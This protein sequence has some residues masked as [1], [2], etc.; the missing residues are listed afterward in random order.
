MENSNRAQTTQSYP[1]RIWQRAISAFSCFAILLSTCGMIL[2]ARAEEQT[3]HCGLEEHQ[4]TE[5]CY[6]RRLVCDHK[7]EEPHVHTEACYQQERV[8]TCGLE[9][10]PGHVHDESCIGEVR[11]LICEDTSE[12]H[13]HDDSCYRVEKGYVC[14]KEAGEG[15]HTHGD[16][17]YEM[18]DV[19]VCKLH[20]HTEECQEDVLICG[21]EAHTHSLSCYSDPEA[22]VESEADWEKSVSKVTLTGVWAED[23][24]AIAKSQLGYEESKRNYA[25]AQDGTV[26]GYTRYGEWYGDPYGSWGAMFVSFCL[27]YAGISRDSVPYE[28]NLGDWIEALSGETWGLYRGMEDGTPRKGDIVF[29]DTNED[30]SA[31]QVGLVS[32]ASVDSLKLIVGD[33]E[34]S[35][36][37]VTLELDSGKLF[38]FVVLPENPERRAARAKAAAAANEAEGEELS[39]TLGETLNVD[40]AAGETVKIP[41][42]PEYTHEYIFQSTGSGDPHGYIYNTEGNQL[43]YNDDSGGNRQFQIAYTLAAGQTYYLW[44]KWRGSNISG[45]IPV[46]LTLGGHDFIQNESG[47]YECGC[48]E[49]ATASEGDLAITLDQSLLVDVMAEETVRIPFVPEITHEYIFQSVGTGNPYGYIYGADG[50]QLASDDNSGGNGQ[51]KMAYTM[52]AGRTYYLGVRW[53]NSTDSGTIP[54]L[55]TLSDNHY[56]IRNESGQWECSCSETVAGDQEFI[57]LGQTLNVYATGGIRKIPFVPKVTHEYVFQFKAPN[58]TYGYIYDADGKMLKSGYSGNGNITY[59]LTAGGI[60]YLGVMWYSSNQ[61]GTIPLL[62]TLGNHSYTKDE[63]GKYKCACGET[64]EAEA[65]AITLDT[66]LDVSVEAGETVAIPFV[67]TITH[68]YV[69]Q[70][71]G[72]GNPY[73]YIYDADGKLLQSN[74]N[75]G[76]N[77]QFKITRT[78][79]AGETYCLGVKWNSSTGSGTIPLLLTLGSHSYAKDEDGQF[80]CTCGKT[81]DG[82]TLDVPL[83]VDVAKGEI[84]KIPF[85]PMITHGYSF[86]ATST[87]HPTDG[88]IYDAD[89]KQLA[90]GHGSAGMFQADYTLTAGQTYYLG[91]KWANFTDSG[92]IPVLLTYGTH[93]YAKNEVGILEC[94]CGQTSIVLG[95]TADIPVEYGQTERLPFVPEFTHE[96]VFSNASYR[97]SYVYLYDANGKILARSNYGSNSQITHTMAAGKTYYLGVGWNGGYSGARSVLLT[98]GSHSYAEDENGEYMCTCGAT[99]VPEGQCGGSVYWRYENGTLRIFGSGKMYDY[100]TGSAP[101]QKLAGDIKRVVVEDGVT[102]IG[103]SAF[104]NCKSLTSVSI[105]GSV[106]NIGNYTFQRCGALTSVVI[107]AGVTSIGSFAFSDCGSLRTAII[108]EGV[109]SIGSQAFYNCD[110]LTSVTIPGSVTSIGSQAFYCCDSLTSVTIPKSVTSVGSDVFSMCAQL[111]TLVWNAENASMGSSSLVRTRN[112][113]LL[114]GKDVDTIGETTFANLEKLEPRTL[115][116][117]GPNY[118]TLPDIRTATLEQ[119]LYSLA[120]GNYYVD[121]QGALYRLHDGEASLAYWPGSLTSCTIPAAVP[122]EDGTP[123]PVTGVD[124]HAFAAAKTLTAINFTAPGRITALADYAFADAAMLAGINGK[125]TEETILPIFSQAETGVQLFTNT[126]IGHENDITDGVLHLEAEHLDLKISTIGSS[127]HT[128]AMAEDHTFLYYTGETATTSVTISNPDSGEIP[129][130]TIV[131]MIYKFD[132]AGATLNYQPGTYTLKALDTG[133][134]YEMTVTEDPGTNCYTIDIERPREGDTLAV[135]FSAAYPSPGT[136]GGNADIWGGILTKEEVEAKGSALIAPTVGYHRVNWTTRPDTFPVTKTLTS[137][138]SVTMKGDGE[139]GAYLDGLNYTIRLSRQ[140]ETLEGMG[141]DF[142]TR[143]DFR[144]VLTLPEGVELSQ[145][146]VQAIRAGN[147]AHTNVSSSTN[148]SFSLD[149]N[150]FLTLSYGRT[151]DESASLEIDEN[152]NLVLKWYSRNQNLSTEIGSPQFTYTLSGKYV[153]VPNPEPDKTYTVKNQITAT[154]HYMYS[155]DRVETALCETAV[156]T[157]EGSLTFQKTRTDSSSHYFGENVTWRITARNPS[158]LPYTRLSRIEDEL[159]DDLYLTAEQLAALFEADPEHQLGVTISRASLCAP[160]TPQTV[161]GMDGV[162]TGST[163]LSNTGSDTPYDGR[164]TQDPDAA[165]STTITLQWGEDGNLQIAFGEEDPVLCEADGATIQAVLDSHGF[166]VT[167]NTR[168]KLCWDRRDAERN[169][170]PLGGGETIVKEIPCKVKDTFMKLNLDEKNRHPSTNY[171]QY[172]TAYAYEVSDPEHKER[173]TSDD[174]SVYLY[175]DF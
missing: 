140:G 33:R 133:N 94:S 10:N 118:L 161:T 167:Q 111:D 66:P 40:V 89:G 175:R 20:A 152:D 129:E 127:N 162:T 134:I 12:D 164:A 4:H 72:T 108:Q 139:N 156:K 15:A 174:D 32:S 145:E 82:I 100:S 165:G 148:E 39:I 3:L 34:N 68:E 93:S 163:S 46:L 91:V 119:S 55:L 157:S 5:G 57:T 90:N 13:V 135:N 154:E 51:F 130:G 110:S 49:T 114:V 144:D 65:M 86:K 171:W 43:A 104:Y 53:Y 149:G 76:G 22:D 141:K 123:I 70:S 83:E 124:S 121:P 151:H 56:F 44:V 9:E 168:Y 138:N 25:V 18:Q 85:I 84:V 126:A 45:T 26:R 95:Q 36:Q 158:A 74:D 97:E 69:F 50:S 48:G 58:S 125:T 107:P 136:A 92:T 147:Y 122:G 1:Y 109:I 78:L 172:N 54:V 117:E 116:F 17:C 6:E 29:L 19:L 143:V 24:I 103:S 64:M 41:F 62:L 21:K 120:A 132:R 63:N 96:Y 81:A 105:P 38:G 28:S 101:W 80:V 102:S 87:G 67:P 75:S 47:Q 52:T 169:T 142:I 113:M 77:N 159:P 2:P 160:H 137:S 99:I 88:Y 106:T 153:R 71:T 37:E 150:T 16:A 42:V 60:Y 7:D 170:P 128:P 8:R 112:L 27:N 79:T 98:L 35:V 73:G 59:S 23:V 31:D 146:F 61:S 131:R 14:G 166:L 30:D 115:R 173:L 11:T 155:V